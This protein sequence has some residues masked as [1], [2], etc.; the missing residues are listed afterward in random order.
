MPVWPKISE[1]VC[2]SGFD[3]ARRFVS[4]GPALAVA[5]TIAACT[6]RSR[7][8]AALDVVDRS[9][10]PA[11]TAVAAALEPALAERIAELDGFERR[12]ARADERAFQIRAV[13]QLAT[14]R[15][16]A[17]AGLRHRAVGVTVR[18]WSLDREQPLEVTA[19]GLTSDDVAADAGFEA[20]ARAALAQATNR[21]THALRLR[22]ADPEDVVA[23][24]RSDDDAVRG[25]AIAAAA[26]RRL[27]AAVEPMG[28]LLATDALPDSVSLDIVG[29][30]VAIGDP[31]G[32]GPIIETVEKRPA[33][34]WPQILFA[35]SELGGRRAEGFLFTVSRGH[36]DPRVRAAAE[37]ALAELERRK[38]PSG[39]PPPP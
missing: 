20:I 36:D 10:D 30:L 15:P 3:R 18:L 26:D 16:S 27:A 2:C 9:G 38:A 7:P 28:A 19:N 25:A 22:E 23:A 33:E 17:R 29:A 6:E 11:G 21:L 14:D 24:I 37:E 13:V 32:V 35:V 31:R 4:F 8:I 5:L 1:R 12:P 39:D 34:Y